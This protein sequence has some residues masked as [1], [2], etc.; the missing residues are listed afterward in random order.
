MREPVD[1][2]LLA[3]VGAAL[4]H[5]VDS[6]A[7]GAWLVP[8]AIVELPDGQRQLKRFVAEPYEAG[9]ARMREAIAGAVGAL[10]VV[11]AFDGYAT[12][13]GERSD[14]VIV[15]AQD[16]RRD[17]AVGFALRYQP[18]SDDAAFRVIGDPMFMGAVGPLMA[19][20]RSNA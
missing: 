13:D 16:V 8:F 12:A 11:I 17:L 14:A 15:E 2:E 5:A 10:R 4:D 6:I 20:R 1:Q 3:L 7:G 18:A 19:P 9:V